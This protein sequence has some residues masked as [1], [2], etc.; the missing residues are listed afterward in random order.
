MYDGSGASAGKGCWFGPSSPVRSLQLPRSTQT[1]RP[2]SV[3]DS[4][5]SNLIALRSP[6]RSTSGPARPSCAVNWSRVASSSSGD[7]SFA[8]ISSTLVNRV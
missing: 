5:W 7:L 1:G 2:S 6:T 8:T 4:F 3:S